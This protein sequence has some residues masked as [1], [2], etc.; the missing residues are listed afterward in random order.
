MQALLTAIEQI[1]E[2]NMGSKNNT[3]QWKT[4]MQDMLKN[5]QGWIKNTTD[6]G[7]KMFSASKTNSC[8]KESYEELGRL[9]IKEIRA[10]R[11]NWDNSRVNKLNETITECEES[12]VEIEKNMNKVRFSSETK[13]DSEEGDE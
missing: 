13:V 5:V 8:L 11:L 4:M 12:L 3:G 9:A 7:V 6:I 2:N 1:R 10:G